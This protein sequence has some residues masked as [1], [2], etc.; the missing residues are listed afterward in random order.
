MKDSARNRKIKRIRLDRAREFVSQ[1]VQNFCN[2]Q[3][4]E[5][6]LSAI[7]TYEQNEKAERAHRFLR[8]MASIMIIASS[9]SEVF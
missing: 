9:L 2:E 1:K 7:E 8:E 6:E 3:E 4:I 5:L